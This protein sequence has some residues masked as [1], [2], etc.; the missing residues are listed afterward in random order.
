MFM[1]W[2][3]SCCKGGK[4]TWNDP[5]IQC[6]L[7]SRGFFC[8]ERKGN[9]EIHMEFWKASSNQHNL[10]RE[11]QNSISKLTTKLR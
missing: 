5:Q 4:T 3:P 8:I 1:D 11:K 6:N 7:Y 2:E 10:K 9:P